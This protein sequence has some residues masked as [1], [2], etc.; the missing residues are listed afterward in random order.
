M[1]A[2]FDIG[3][4]NK[5]FF[6]F[7]EQYAPAE[8][9]SIQLPQTVDEDGSPCEDLEALNAW[10]SETL[11]KALARADI[12]ALNF[13]TYGASFVHLD[14]RLEPAAPLYNYLKS[15][16]E[17]LLEA[18]Y[19]TYGGRENFS[20]E[21]ASPPLGMLNSGLQLYWLKK[22]R[23]FVYE[24][25]R[26]SLHL[27]QYCSFYFTR[28][29]Y[30]EYTSIG[31]HTGLWDFSKGDYHRWVYAEGIDRLLPAIVESTA[32]TDLMLGGR[33]VRVGP[34]IHDS[35]A[36]LLPYLMNSDKPFLLLSTGTWSI[37]LNPFNRELLSAAELFRDCLNFLRVDGYPVKASRLFLGNEHELQTH[38]LSLHFQ[39]PSDYHQHLRFDP[40]IYGRLSANPGACFHME[41]LSSRP[42]DPAVSDLSRFASYEEAYHG[43]LIE[44]VDRQVDAIRL[45]MGQ[46]AVEKIYV[47]GGFADNEIFLRLL[48]LRLPQFEWEPSHH[49]QG[50]AL[51][52]ALAVGRILP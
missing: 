32:D 14:D 12:R 30:S 26:H 3:K 37:C 41:S 47:D 13:S 4:T 35:S 6:L 51:G 39:K 20:L 1:I 15:F 38:K 18:F 31:C 29:L 33:P 34:G 49:P 43:L 5:K 7:D 44:L 48:A 17:P 27:P 45:A 36:A 28:Q 9:E 22:E 10:M 42:G 8:G 40:D 24:R 46:T 11:A 2:I 23:P 52:A 25:I 19:E 21:T 16:P 50:S